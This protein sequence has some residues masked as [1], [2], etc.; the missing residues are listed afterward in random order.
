M[1]GLCRDPPSGARWRARPGSAFW[2]NFWKRV[3][4]NARWLA[5]AL[6]TKTHVRE[7][8]LGVDAGFPPFVKGHVA[9]TFDDGG[10]DWDPGGDDTGGS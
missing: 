2:G 10:D 4:K 8:T 9:V 6:V 7:W 1:I 3:E 5:P